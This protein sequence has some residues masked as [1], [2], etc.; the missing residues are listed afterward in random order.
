MADRTWTGRLLLKGEDRGISKSAQKVETAVGSATN[1]MKRFGV[2]A[3]AASAAALFVGS[4][5]KI[6][7]FEKS[8]SDLA[9]ITG[10]SGK[11]LDRLTEAS[12]RI[13][14]TT[15]LSASQAAEAFKLI[16]SAKPDLLENVDALEQTTKA[17]V[18]LAEAAG[19]D[20]P[21]AATA[22]GESLNQF[23]KGAEEA[24]RFMNVL[25]AGAKFGSS[26]ISQTSEA[27]RNAGTVAKLAGL[28]FETTNASIQALAAAGIKGSDAGTKL[29]SVLIKLQTQANDEFNPAVVG[30]NE[31]LKNLED[32]NLSITEKVAIFGERSVAT[33][34]VLIAQRDVLEKVEGQVTGTSEAYDQ[35]AKR[36]DNLDG[37]IKRLTSAFE[38]FQINLGNKML[39]TMRTVIQAFTDIFNA[40]AFLTNDTGIAKASDEFSVL[41]ATLKTLFVTGSIIKNMLDNVFDSLVFIGRS[42]VDALSGNFDLIDDHFAEFQAKVQQNGEDIATAAFRSFQPE[43]A[44]A[45]DAATASLV[46]KV[47]EQQEAIAEATAVVVQTAG[48]EAAAKAEELARA[49]AEKAFID[50]ELLLESI[51]ETHRSEMEILVE[52]DAQKIAEL[53]LLLENKL[54]TEDEFN[55]KF[56]DADEAFQAARLKI[57]QKGLSQIQKFE[58]LTATNKTKFVLAEA[59]KLTQGVAQNN[60]TMFKINKVSAIANAVINT[61]QAI[62]RTMADYPYPINIALAALTAAAGFA[63]IQSIKSTQFQGGGG[64]TTPSAA[65]SVPTLNNNPVGGANEVP[66]DTLLAG[67]G[68]GGGQNI[69]IDI[70][71]L[72]QAGLLPA[73]AVRGLIESINES[74]GDGVNLN[75]DAGESGG[76]QGG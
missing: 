45:I 55:T 8:I 74:L 43:A 75:V 23:G 14:Q 12:K 26:E 22:L 59:T 67:Q 51:R 71:G 48:M 39:P 72:S 52:N 33:A 9:A 6:K 63:Q 40:I 49:K 36:T 35:A 18:T 68:G 24:E 58:M 29:R 17:A 41:D 66:I 11:D 5:K 46:P 38:A 31:A 15:T 76:A 32:A 54:L 50:R 64:G 25:A 47:V 21:T 56:L 69:T 20:L 57:T 65:G 19:L 4:A 1:A 62:T 28:S 16:A 42:L 37:D 2:I 73:D 3:V 53:E 34:D 10:A 70:D 44:A 7:E 13:G 30:M 61:G 27:L 60:K